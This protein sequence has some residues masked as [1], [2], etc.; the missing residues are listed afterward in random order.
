[1]D[2]KQLISRA[3]KKEFL[4]ADEGQ[5]LYENTYNDPFVFDSLSVEHK[6]LYN[7]FSGTFNKLPPNEI[8]DIILEQL[9]FLARILK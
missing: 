1:M 9:N 3:L 5:F 7:N 2:S 4:S 6:I 8:P